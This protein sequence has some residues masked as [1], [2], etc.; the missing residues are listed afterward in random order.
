MAYEEEEGGEDINDQH[1]HGGNEMGEAAH[2]EFGSPRGKNLGSIGA[3]HHPLAY[4]EEEKGDNAGA[5]RAPKSNALI[6]GED[7]GSSGNNQQMMGT[8]NKL[9]G[10]GGNLQ[11]ASGLIGAN[12]GV[13]LSSNSGQSSVSALDS[14]QVDN[15]VF[16]LCRRSRVSRSPLELAA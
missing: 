9:G 4:E 10:S 5:M 7:H 12:G 2:H 1:H 3:H 15:V 14:F 6:L 11:A 16:S 13:S 8:A